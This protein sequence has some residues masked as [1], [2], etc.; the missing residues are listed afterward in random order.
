MFFAF[1]SLVVLVLISIIVI[2]KVYPTHGWHGMM[3]SATIERCICQGVHLA[4]I[5]LN[6]FNSCLFMIIF[7]WLCSICRFGPLLL[8][9][10]LEHGS[11]RF[12]VVYLPSGSWLALCSRHIQCG[13]QLCYA[14]IV[15][16]SYRKGLVSLVVFFMKINGWNIQGIKKP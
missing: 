16:F 11:L 5:A 8:P 2:P 6:S 7:G 9:L 3:F 12:I 15:I 14:L 10:S 13:E 1:F 4:Y